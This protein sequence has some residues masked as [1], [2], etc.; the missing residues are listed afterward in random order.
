MSSIPR[1]IE[2]HEEGPREGFQIEKGP[3]S[4]E[5][6][7]EMID[8]LSETGV[9]EIQVCSFVNPKKVPGWADA[10]QVVAGFKRKPGVRY[11]ALWLNEKGLERALATGRI[12][13][14]GGI[15]PCPSTITKVSSTSF[16]RKRCARRLLCH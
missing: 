4:T 1:F 11:T 6:K 5:Q 7:I 14:K 16:R 13:V 15:S 3:I 2:I 9:K 8:A 10:E 12:D